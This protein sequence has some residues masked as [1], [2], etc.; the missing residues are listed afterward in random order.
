MAG[1][2]LVAQRASLWKC[3]P[4]LADKL[5]RGPRSARKPIGFQDRSHQKNIVLAG[6]LAPLRKP[7]KNEASL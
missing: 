7:V 5:V 1:L 3:G 2:L 4:H 6:F